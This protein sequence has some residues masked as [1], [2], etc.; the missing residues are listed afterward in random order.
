MIVKTAVPPRFVHIGFNFRGEPPIDALEAL[1][2]NALDWLRYDP[3]CWILYTSTD[4]DT[5]RDRIRKITG[6][7]FL[8]FEFDRTA[9]V[10]GYQPTWVWQWLQ[11]DR[12]RQRK[13]D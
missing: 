13:L 1:F 11:K 6:D 2:G 8:M 10:S 4:L 3:S 5:W 12:S 7:T 9:Y